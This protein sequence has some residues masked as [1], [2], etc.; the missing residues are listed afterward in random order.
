MS[1]NNAA[2][3]NSAI[4]TVYITHPHS[5]YIQVQY[6]T[7]ALIVIMMIMI[8]SILFSGTVMHNPGE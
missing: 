8:A 7:A 4:T 2:E 3:W 1:V 5:P 6:L